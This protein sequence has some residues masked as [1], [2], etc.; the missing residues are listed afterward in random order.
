MLPHFF[1]HY[2]DLVDRYFVLDNGSTDS[3]LAILHAHP[4][5]SVSH[6]DVSGDSFVDEERRI[7]DSIWKQSKNTADWVIILDIDEFIFR[8][9]FEK[10]LRRCTEAGVTAIRAIGYEMVAD[11]FPSTDTN[12]TDTVTLGVRSAGHDKLCVF[13]PA[14]LTETHFEPGRHRANPKGRVVFLTDR[15]C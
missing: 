14:A 11:Y 9:D 10:Y 3:S 2:D 6:F 7:S 8:P 5:V 12:L 4:N 1:R 15:K 13:N